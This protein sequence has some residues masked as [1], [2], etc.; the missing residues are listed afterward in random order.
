[1]DKNLYPL[2]FTP[3]DTQRPWGQEKWLLADLGYIDSEVLGGW[4]DGNTLS[5]LM[6][7]YLEKMVG[8]D[9]FEYYGLQF[10]VSVKVI[11]FDGETPVFVHADDTVAEQRYD[12]LGKTAVWMVVSAE[13]GAHALLGFQR[14]IT[15][16]ELYA[17]GQSGALKELLNEIPVR[18]GDVLPLE[19]GIPYAFCGKAKVIEISEASSLVFDLTDPEDLVEAFDFVGREGYKI[20]DQVGDN[21]GSAGNPHFRV[22]RELGPEDGEEEFVLHIT[23]DG[24]SLTLYPA[25][26]DKG[27]FPPCGIFVLPGEITANR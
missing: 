5:E 19:P 7:T 8:D 2:Q 21:V 24:S 4:L 18:A 15:A 14:R 27:A 13:P 17:A 12:S 22:K 6:Q 26:G 23:A 9:T 11:E 16:P 10:P 20:P 1:M 3:V 25:E